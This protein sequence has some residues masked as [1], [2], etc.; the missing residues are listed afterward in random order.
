MHR[1]RLI[2]RVTVIV[3]LGAFLHYTLPRHDIARVTGTEVMRQ[4]FSSWNRIFYAQADAGNATGSTRD[5][6]LVNTQAQSTWLFGLIRGGLT[7]AVY[8]NEDTG[9][10]WPP[11]FKFD[12]ADVQAQAQG[13]AQSAGDPRWVVITHYGWRNRLLSIYPNV[14]AIRPIPDPR[15][16]S[17]RATPPD[18][19][20][21]PWFNIGFFIA[22]GLIV[23]GLRR[24]WNRLLRRFRRSPAAS[25]DA[26]P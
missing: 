1:L 2:L 13:L 4:D 16:A 20:I 23:L 6:R 19:R 21:V 17:D 18:Y 25:P 11:Y 14:T 22:L 8:R 12:S 15:P 26:G 7:T 10:G 3:I 5:L 9:W 24:G